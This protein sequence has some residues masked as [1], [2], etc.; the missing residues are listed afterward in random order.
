MSQL[1]NRQKDL[2]LKIP[3][4]VSVIGL[5]G[6]GS[7]VALN[8]AL[9]GVRSLILVDNDI[10]EEHNLNRTPFK[11]KHIGKP[12]V[13][14]IAELIAERRPETKVIPIAKK[15]EELNEF[16]M[17]EINETTIV[18]CR[19]TSTPFINSPII[20]G[21]DGYKITI[22]INPQNK[23]VWGEERVTY[24]ITPSYVVPPQLI[25]NLITLYL[26]SDI[27]IEKEIIKT[28]DVRNLFRK[29][30]EL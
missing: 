27:K 18:D 29:V 25:A 22:H 5:G 12:K 24:T 30:M 3:E 2:N 16:E 7:W 6:V 26:T 8:L 14:G 19:D 15:W 4:K 21:Y 17:K 11:I 13:Y 1:Y 10:V 9:V 20:G 23:T 28:F